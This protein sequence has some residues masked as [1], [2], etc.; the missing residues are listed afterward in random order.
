MVQVAPSLWSAYRTARPSGVSAGTWAL[1]LGELVCFL[2]YGL[3]QPDPRLIALGVTGVTA[4]TLMLARIL[5]TGMARGP[6][7]LAT[8]VSGRAREP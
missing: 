1:I 6:S 4:S 5:W 3:A 2:V 7:G 8:H